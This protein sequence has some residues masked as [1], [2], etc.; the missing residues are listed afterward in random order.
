MSLSETYLKHVEQDGRVLDGAVAGVV[1]EVPP[2]L[3]NGDVTW[4]CR[5]DGWPRQLGI[6]VNWK[7]VHFTSM[8][9]SGGHF[10]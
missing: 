10:P 9:G 1:L 4:T 6:V 5:V 8:Y 7:Q 3:T 2:M